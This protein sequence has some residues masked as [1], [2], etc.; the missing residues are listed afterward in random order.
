M[1]SGVQVL[2]T[3]NMAVRADAYVLLKTA[4][5]SVAAQLSNPETPKE[6][7]RALRPWTR[8]NV[9]ATRE[10]GIIGMHMCVVSWAREN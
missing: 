9:Q 6:M 4:D 1:L 2:F 3:R 8:K 5:A 10:Y 7:K